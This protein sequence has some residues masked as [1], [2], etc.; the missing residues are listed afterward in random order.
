MPVDLYIAATSIGVRA[1]AFIDAMKTSGP[2]SIER[3]GRHSRASSIAMVE[4]V[5][6]S[7][8]FKPRFMS[9]FHPGILYPRLPQDT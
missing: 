2:T 8:R 9:S 4:I 5:P 7:A 1:D 3:T 6:R